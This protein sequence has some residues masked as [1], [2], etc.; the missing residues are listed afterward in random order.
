MFI[1]FSCLTELVR[2]SSTML[3]TNTHPCLV[4][5]CKVSVPGMSPWRVT[6]A[7]CVVMNR[8][9]PQIFITHS[10]HTHAHTHTHTH[11]PLILW[12]VPIYLYSYTYIWNRYSPEFYLSYL[13]PSCFILI[14]SVLFIWCAKLNNL[15]SLMFS[16]T[17]KWFHNPKM[18][19]HT[20]LESNSGIA[21]EGLQDGEIL[22]Y[23]YAIYL[24]LF[25]NCGW[26]ELWSTCERERLRVTSGIWSHVPGKVV[27]LP[28]EMGEGGGQ[29]TLKWRCSWMEGPGWS[30]GALVPDFPWAFVHSH[31]LHHVNH[32]CVSLQVVGP[33]CKI[34]H[35]LSPQ[36][37][38]VLMG[39]GVLIGR[40]SLSQVCISLWGSWDSRGGP[41]QSRLRF[42]AVECSRG[43]TRLCW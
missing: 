17:K 36:E 20:Q 1:S 2:T 8:L 26:S 32:T 4:P 15:I 28:L 14:N 21:L 33:S 24:I 39:P 25:F 10:K 31:V 34:S 41:L 6:F 23:S 9:D 37:G 43:I 27:L 12:P 29:Q 11:L 3:N 30:L 13:T 18:H 7:I 16:F 40:L 42:A 19:G 5:D 22:P 35:V 38:G